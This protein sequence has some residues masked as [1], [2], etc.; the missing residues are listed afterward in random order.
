MVN[1]V[2]WRI[3]C[4]KKF[5]SGE[6]IQRLWEKSQNTEV[7]NAEWLYSHE[8]KSDLSWPTWAE[9]TEEDETWLWSQQDPRLLMVMNWD[10]KDHIQVNKQ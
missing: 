5:I 7:K 6:R 1:K 3:K 8:N 2:W 10:L 4:V 9:N